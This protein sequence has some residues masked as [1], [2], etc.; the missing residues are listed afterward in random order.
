[1]VGIAAVRLF[2]GL[3][4]DEIKTILGAAITRKY[5]RSEALTKGDQP[6]TRLVLVTRGAADLYIVTDKGTK[7]LV[8]RLVAGNVVGMACFLTEPM[9]YLGT[10]TAIRETEA[11]TWEHRTVRRLAAK[12]PQF[13]ENALRIALEYIATY[14][15]RHMSL[16]TDKAQERL[17][18]ALTNTASRSGHVLPS[19]VEIDIKNEE[20]A[21]LADVSFFTTSRVLNKWQR[22]GFVEKS[23]GKVVIRC[24]EK[25]LADQ[26]HPSGDWEL[27]RTAENC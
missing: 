25:L 9:G 1:M 16:V 20:L 13:P 23:R 26:S 8:R 2:A 4:K 11:L 15:Y 7:L 24:P 6:A 17:V 14:A 27:A 12:Y 10:A 18:R 22:Q 5:K 21:S 3:G 19:G